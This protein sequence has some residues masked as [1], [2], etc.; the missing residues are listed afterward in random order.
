[1]ILSIICT[2][3]S[4]P[5]VVRGNPA[6][7]VSIV[8]LQVRR[9][10]SYYVQNIVLIMALLS[11]MG[12]LCYAMEPDNIGD[13]L[14]TNFTLIL[15]IV[16]FKLVLAQSLPKVA[17]NTLIDWYMI[18]SFVTL[19]INCVVCCV[20]SFY[21]SSSGQFDAN[22][23]AL[24]FSTSLVFATNVMWCYM[25]I[26]VKR[27]GR[28]TRTRKMKAIENKNWYACRFSSPSYLPGV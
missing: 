2:G 27:R 4:E 17:Y 21:G 5:L 9:F 10:A 28:K 26:N 16:A 6:H 14:S 15:T 1:M 23:W 25:A 11:I 19:T 12:L 22:R 7:K 13:R 20:P 18:A 3:L 8:K 24:Y